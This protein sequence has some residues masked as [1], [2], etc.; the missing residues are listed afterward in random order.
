MKKVVAMM[1]RNAS[2]EVVIRRC[3][4]SSKNEPLFSSSSQHRVGRVCRIFPTPSPF[5]DG[6]QHSLSI[7]LYVRT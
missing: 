1:A 5:V 6:N 4:L 7:Y 2:V 3:P